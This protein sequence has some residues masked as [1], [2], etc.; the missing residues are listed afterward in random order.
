MENRT[1][2]GRQNPARNEADLKE[3]ALRLHVQNRGKWT[4]ASKVPL[5]TQEDLAL[6]YSP[7]V[8]EPCRAIAADPEAVFRY[9]ARGNL[10]AVVSDGSAVL[11][12][13]DIGPEAAL[14][15][16]EGKALL[17]K[18]FADIDAVPLVLAERDVDEI[19]RTVTRLSPTFGGINL[20]DIAAPRCF[21]VERKLQAAVDIPVFHDDQHGT[22]IVVAAGLQNAL[23]LVGKRLEEV[24]VV[25]EG[26][27]ASGLAT[28]ALL[29][30][31]GVSDLTLVDSRGTIYPGR[32]DGMNPFKEE[33]A[34]RTNPRRVRGGLAEALAGAD[35]AVGLA[36]GGSMTR[37]MVR[38]MAPDPI[39]FAL[40]NPEPAIWP[41]EAK[42][43]GA[44]VVATGRSD[45][46]NQLNNVLAFPGIFR[47][48]LDVR[49]R[50]INEAMKR[51]AVRAIAD[52]VA[53]EEL[54]A[55][56]IIPAPLDRRVAP[57]VAAAVA[58]AAV[59][60]G[61]ARSPGFDSFD[62]YI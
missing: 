53:P 37:E 34:Q 32:P 45:Y 6:A 1:G 43:A 27:G 59:R 62:P 42:A 36:R 55:D 46:P 61:V 54:S 3:A 19:V 51:A 7:G 28:A 60:S 10:V 39:V 14:P 13:G 40:A 38:A 49:A 12:L 15:V 29:L 4:T 52:L 25:I 56:Y 21:A 26:A 48:A 33:L 44:A 58:E 57:A 50:E 17:F 5:Q 22:A 9:T 35:V 8:A 20:E 18:A 24:R 41:E 2:D 31:L 16:M 47:G 30:D 23:K 11:G